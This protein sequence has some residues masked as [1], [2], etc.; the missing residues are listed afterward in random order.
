MLQRGVKLEIADINIFLNQ[1]ANGLVGWQWKTSKDYEQ[2]IEFWRSHSISIFSDFISTI[3]FESI[4]SLFDRDLVSVKKQLGLVGM[5]DQTLF[6]KKVSQLKWQEQMKIFIALCLYKGEYKIGFDIKNMQCIICRNANTFFL[7][8][9]RLSKKYKLAFNLSMNDNDNFRLY[10][11]MIIS[12]SDTYAYVDRNSNLLDFEQILEKE[13]EFRKCT[14]GEYKKLESFHYVKSHNFLY[15][16]L[17]GAFLNHILVGVIACLSPV[18]ELSNKVI[19]KN[20]VLKFA[21]NR[22]QSCIRIIV[23]PDYRGI[24]IAGK[25]I[26]YANRELDC[27]IFEMRSSIFKGTNIVQSWG[28]QVVDRSYRDHHPAYDNLFAQLL[29]LGIDIDNIENHSKIEDLSVTIKE[30]IHLLAYQRLQEID[31]YQW[32]Y[33]EGLIRKVAKLGEKDYR[34]AKDIY[35]MAYQQLYRKESLVTVLKMCKKWES[36]AYLFKTEQFPMRQ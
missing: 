24:G 26:K 19:E 31:R 17:Y 20:K 36:E 27:D 1:Q 21:S 15:D 8:L 35:V 33:Y 16:T 29:V 18:R 9:H 13:I 34:E 10:F 30:D 7:N 32:K 3:R 2:I 5:L 25:L 11:H 23:H 12:Y 4:F 6:H 22:F 14:Q 28:G